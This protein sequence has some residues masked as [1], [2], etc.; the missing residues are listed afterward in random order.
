MV[1]AA[2]AL[3]LFAWSVC[4]HDPAATPGDPIRSNPVEV[5]SVEPAPS[6]PAETPTALAPAAAPADRSARRRAFAAPPR[7]LGTPGRPDQVIELEGVRIHTGGGRRLVIADQH[8][9]ATPYLVQ[10]TG[11][12]QPA[13]RTRIET[14]GGVIRGYLPHHT[15]AIDLTPAQAKRLTREPHVHWV[16][17]YEPSFK[18]QPFLAEL[19]ATP[20]G[21]PLTVT[22]STF[23]AEDLDAVT[24]ALTAAGLPVLDQANG[25]RWSWV[26]TAIAPD[27]LPT[28]AALDRV[29][30]IEEYVEPGLL[31]DRAVNGTLMRVTNVWAR[32]LS[33]E[34]QIIGHADTGLDRG[35]MT[36][37]HQ[38]LAG[39][40]LLAFARG[41][42]TLWND[43]NGHGTHTA[44]SIVGNG[45][46]STGTIRGVAWQAKLIHQSLLDNGGGLGG[47][48]ANLNDLYAQ[49]YTN[50]ARIHADS[51]GADVF[52]SYTTSSRQSDEF[53]WDHPDMLLVFAAGNAGFD[54]D[55]GVVDPDSI[56]SPAT[57]KNV[58]TVG[59]AESDRPPGSGGLSSSTY[60]SL[61]PFD[62]P[63]DPIRSDYVSQPADGTNQGLSA[64]SS[65]GPTDD[66]RVKPDLVAPGNNIVSVRSRAAA[67]SAWGV[68]AN[69]NYTFN[70]GT[71]MSTPLVAGAAALVREYFQKFRGE[72]AP[73]AALVK[74]VLQHGAR[75]MSPGQYGTGAA[76][77]I[78]ATTPNNAEGW[79]HLDLA[80]SLFPDHSTW[81]YHDHRDGLAAPGDTYDLVFH[82]A[83]GM[84]KLTMTYTDFPATAGG[85]IKLVNDL[86]LSLLGPGTSNTV[87]DRIN[88]SE[89][90]R[91]AITTPGIHTARVT[92][93]NVPSGPQPFAL[94]ISGPV[95]DPPVIRHT[96]L[97]NTSDTNA[98][99]WVE[100]EIISAAPLPTNA[101]TLFWKNAAETGAFTAVTMTP[102]TGR[103]FEAEIPAHPDPS[104]N[105]YYLAVTSGVF[106]VTDPADAP[107]TTH[108]YLVTA[109][110]ALTVGGSP[111]AVFSVSPPYGVNLIP[112][113]NVVRLTAPAATNLSPGMRVAVT[114]WTGTGDVPASGSTHDVTIMLRQPS[115]ITWIWETQYALTQTSSV[116]GLITTTTWW[117]VWAMASTVTAPMEPTYQNTNYGF[118][119][120]T[121][122]G[123]RQPDG[124]AVAANPAP[125][126]AMFGPR[127]AAALYQRALVDANVDG[128]A[129]WWAAFHFGTNTPVAGDDPDSDGFTNLKEFLDRTNP[130]DAASVPQPPHITHTP[131]A[132]PQASPAPWTVAATITDNH[133][134]QS[135]SVIA[136]N[137]SGPWETFPLFATTNNTYEGTLSLP[138][139][140]GDTITYRIEASDPASLT[141][142]NGLHAF[143][144]HHPILE[145]SPADFGEVDVSA[146]TTTQVF[147]LVSNAGLADLHWTL[148]CALYYDNMDL[149]TGAWT[150]TGAN[151]VWHQQDARFASTP[152]AWHFGNGPFGQYPDN[153]H[154]WL[155]SEPFILSAPAELTFDHWASMEYDTDQMDDHYW[156]GGVVEASIDG[157]I[158]WT[159]ITPNGG[160]PHRITDNPAS[161]FPPDT[162]C[163]GA[164]DDWEPATFD[165]SAFTHETVQIRF[166]FG[167]DGYVRDE[168]WYIDN[169]RISYLDDSSWQWLAL[170]TNGLVAPGETSAVPVTLDTATL[171]MGERS[172]AILLLDSND[173]TRDAPLR[174]PIILHNRSRAITVTRTEHGTV[175]PLG[176]ALVNAGE[177]LV[178]T[179]AA[180]TFY[181]AGAVLTNGEPDTA[182]VRADHT[183]YTWPDIQDSGTVH[184]VFMEKL[185]AGLVPEWW[186]FSEN[187]TNST[188]A[189]EAVTDTDADGMLA[190]QE[191]RT[192]T[193]PHN[194]ASV[195]LPVVSVVSEPGQ[196]LVTWLSF[197]ND[198]LRYDVHRTTNL[199]EGFT[200]IATNLAATP[201][202]NTFTNP[203]DGAIFETYR[204]IAQPPAP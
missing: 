194:A 94:V 87:A 61:W 49:T 74:A 132:D 71:S 88:P 126:I 105:L 51:W 93:V 42:G 41:R 160:Y 180:D 158:T 181:E 143:I 32:G 106:T 98:S 167:S 72:P 175:T 130:R 89:Q 192:G 144:I 11:P 58:L 36:N 100:A 121:V 69:T 84:V 123:V 95:T 104:E 190:W 4:Q 13:W 34:G 170:A 67:G 76:R 16:Q 174:I 109:P 195:A 96:P 155:V 30:W 78:P 91:I 86:D 44:G 116:P 182:F 83:T 75:P 39:R 19:A 79:G 193:D 103:W 110:I 161:P 1:A 56:G 136:R 5:S 18:I 90:L 29:Q 3:F 47:L 119:G 26:R 33:G 129:D 52:G 147:L 62:Y 50:G 139:V 66:G 10:F 45:A 127:T 153:A 81:M 164:T 97:A 188:P 189:D 65:R 200:V 178:L 38:D 159:M 22:L 165:L 20:D 128:I 23:A 101:A 115:S 92:A 179:L 40:V 102:S 85:G 145:A 59:A 17:P 199:T 154:A 163:Y 176:T 124:S 82:A 68:S 107:A 15:L 70:G 177:A 135:A 186:L 80:T 169:V 125:G 55:D 203:G 60:G 196:V 2:G 134:V 99:R 6:D 168:G 9:R 157:G 171:P 7:E 137:G 120:W 118:T 108:R 131:L 150:H 53:M 173:P 27:D 149:G 37:L 156:D 117:A 197:T 63:Y 184:V 35:V 191:Y 14:A 8:R 12:V 122:D 64:F 187:L 48:P 114:G 46:M 204:V 21:Q 172:E 146:N 152:T 138:G 148:D 198:T 31:N 43:P 166:R 24:T 133:R 201:P 25:R 112:S 185:A 73:S 28:L 183:T 202:V 57:A 77:E 142:T 162:P 140:N 141:T 54:S 111:A 113:G 151:D